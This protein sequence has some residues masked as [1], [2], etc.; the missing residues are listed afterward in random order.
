MKRILLLLGLL[1]GLAPRAFAAAEHP[2]EFSFQA[3]DAI[4]QDAARLNSNKDSHYFGDSRMTYDLTPYSAVG[5]EAGWIRYVDRPNGVKDGHLYEV[6]LMGDFIL[7]YPLA[8]TNNRVVPYLIGGAGVAIGG[9]DRSQG[10]K[11]AGI[12]VKSDTEFAW[13][14]GG[15]I[16]LFLTRQ[17]ALFAEGSFFYS[18]YDPKVTGGDIGGK[19]NT[20]SI[21]AGGGLTIAF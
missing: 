13:K 4:P 14:A 15:G 6:P 17:I 7:K 8:F 1:I 10:I 16:Q 2:L 3:G 19:I 21:L 18:K 11:D 9:Y 20:R 12:K 5:V